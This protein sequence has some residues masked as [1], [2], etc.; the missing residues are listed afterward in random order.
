MSGQAGGGGEMRPPGDDR[1]ER[2]IRY[3]LSVIIVVVSFVYVL[4]SAATSGAVPLPDIRYVAPFVGMAIVVVWQLDLADFR[5]LL[6]LP[7]GPFARAILDLLIAA[8][9]KRRDDEGGG[10]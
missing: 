7:I 9:S 10:R 5:S 3:V 6:R 1:F 8:G 2:R 4:V